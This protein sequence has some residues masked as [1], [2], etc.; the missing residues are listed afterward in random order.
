MKVKTKLI[1]RKLSWLTLLFIEYISLCFTVFSRAVLY[2]IFDCTY[3]YFKLKW[4]EIRVASWGYP[5]LQCLTDQ[6]LS[7]SNKK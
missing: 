1:A 2:T 4:S 3:G 6:L 5:D 7:L